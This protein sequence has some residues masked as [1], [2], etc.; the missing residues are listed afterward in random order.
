MSSIKTM[1]DLRARVL[2]A[3]DDLENGEI[4][5]N[6]ASCIA[7]LSDTVISGLKSEMQYAILTNQK[8]CIPFYGDTSGVVLDGQL[9]KSIKKLP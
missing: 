7:K 2:K 1:K 3:F 6:E 4:D 8:P 9:I 5:I